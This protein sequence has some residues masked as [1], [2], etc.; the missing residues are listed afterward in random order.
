VAGFTGLVKGDKNQSVVSEP[1]RLSWGELREAIGNKEES[2]VVQPF[3][4]KDPG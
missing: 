2:R 1:L 4:R 3:K